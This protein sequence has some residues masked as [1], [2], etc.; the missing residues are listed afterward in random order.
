[1]FVAQWPGGGY[2]FQV[3]EVMRCLRAGELESPLV[4]WADTLTVA[5]TLDRWLASIHA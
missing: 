4:P 5:R 2:T 3:Q 1:M